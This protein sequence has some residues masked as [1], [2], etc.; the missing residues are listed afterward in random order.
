MTL[1]GPGTWEA[2]RAAV[3]AAV[4]AADLVLGG[5]PAAYA[6]CRPPGHHATRGGFGGSCYLNNAAAAAARLRARCGRVAVI[7][8]DAHHGNGTQAIFYEDPGVL[9]GSVHVDPGA[10]WF[11]HFLG[12]DDE[13]GGPAPI[14][15]SAGA[16][17]GDGPWLA[18]V[19][20]LADWAR[21]GG[22]AALV[23][24]LGVDA[25]GATPRA[26]SQVTAERLSGAGRALGA[27]R[28]ADRRGPG[29]RLRPGH[30]RRA[31]GRGA[32]G[33]RGG[34]LITVPRIAVDI[35]A[36]R[37]SRDLRLL[38]LGNFVSGLGTQAALVAL[39]YQLY[40]QT[41]SAFLTGLLGRGR[42]RAADR[43]GAARRRD[44][45][46]LRPPAAAAA[47]PDRA[48]AVAGGAGRARVARRP[49]GAGCSTCSAGCS[50]ASARC[51]TS[52]R[53]AIV[54]N[55]V[56]PAQPALGAGAQLRALPAD[57]GGRPGARRPADRRG[58]GRRGL[59]R[60]RRQLPGD[61]RRARRDGAAAAARAA[62]RT[63]PIG[64]SIAEGLRFVRGNQAL[65]GS[66]AIDLV[67]MTFGM[68]RALFPVLVG[69]RLRR[70][71]RGH[72]ACCS[73]PS[74][75]ARR[76]RRSRRAGSSTRGGSG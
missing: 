26:R 23:V 3:D 1:I 53:S 54:P 44:R 27:L 4:T 9:V 47:R 25:A 43:D 2:A 21:A 10:G 74:R 39:P 65:M 51:R 41:G 48:R 7:D 34:A 8:V 50:P 15:T 17:T 64:R 73:R 49:A 5:E 59:R 67:A 19:T 42:A 24:A 63:P 29:G 28:P 76:S 75:R 13:P 62:A 68:P 66:F 16:G 56:D 71:R 12:F 52:A 58:R 6:C 69:Q 38:V 61:G 72:R 45:R 33:P 40:V 70:G 22:A 46:P 20:D 14:A 35:S 30:A 36:L 55:L 32:D 37:A 57:A 60:R 31:G 18:A 11:P